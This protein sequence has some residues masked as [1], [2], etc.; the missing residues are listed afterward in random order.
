MRLPNN[1]RLPDEDVSLIRLLADVIQQVNGINEG[2]MNVRHAASTAAPT[3]LSWAQGDIIL[4]STPTELGTS[5]NKYV[6]T[7]FVCVVSGTPGTWVQAR[8]LTG[9]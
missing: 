3:T 6:I 2:R 7:Q 9:N 4:N 1:P 8:S 5:P